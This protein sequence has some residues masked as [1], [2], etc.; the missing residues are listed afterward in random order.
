MSKNKIVSI[1][2]LL[3]LQIYGYPTADMNCGDDM[4][5]HFTANCQGERYLRAVNGARKRL[6]N[7]YNAHKEK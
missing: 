4:I 5:A 3:S 2:E 1:I 7:Y 6:Y